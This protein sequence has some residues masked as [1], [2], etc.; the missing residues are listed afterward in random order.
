MSIFLNH[1]MCC[2]LD[3]AVD[4]PENEN[5]RD[6]ANLGKDQTNSKSKPNR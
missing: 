5:S 4:Q 3:D 6:K 2:G 1:Y